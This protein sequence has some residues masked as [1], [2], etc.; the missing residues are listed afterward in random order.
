MIHRLMAYSI[1]GRTQAM[2]KVTAV[3]LFLLR[4]MDVGPAVNVPFLLAQYLF[5]H[6]AGRKGGSALSGG[7]FIG[8]LAAHFGL[9]TPQG[10]QGLHV[11]S[12]EARVFDLTEL[13]KLGY[14]EEIEE[15]WFWVPMGP[16]RP[17]VVEEGVLE[18]P[19]AAGEGQAEPEAE[20]AAAEAAAQPAPGRTVAHRLGLVEQ[21]VTGLRG[22]VQEM[23]HD[24]FQLTRTSEWIVSSITQ[25]LQASGRPFTQFPEDLSYRRRTRARHDGAGPS[26]Q[27]PHPED[28]EMQDP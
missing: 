11:I 21:A 19:A 20:P 15:E 14:I 9:T 16:P 24:I 12:T 25:L 2:E 26:H 4:S 13:E 1:C 23:R 3:D 27:Q 17:E 22:D 28:Q 7:H 8:R 5:C 10:L 18:I 6:A